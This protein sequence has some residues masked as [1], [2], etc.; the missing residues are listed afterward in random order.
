MSFALTP[1][2]IL[3]CRL[4]GVRPSVR[5]TAAKAG[6]Y[7]V[8]IVNEALELRIGNKV[9]EVGAGSGYHAAKIAEQVGPQ[10]RVYTVKMRPYLGKAGRSN[11]ETAGSSYIV[12][13]V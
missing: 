4:I 12:R 1:T 2:T 7:M 5:H 8:A 11:L 10:A 9:L 3:P 13:F 6:R